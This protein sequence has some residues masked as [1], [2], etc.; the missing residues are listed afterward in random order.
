MKTPIVDFVKAYADTDT[1]R[2]HMPGHKGKEVIGS[3]KWDITEIEGA[4]VLYSANGIIKQSEENAAELFET[5]K[6]VYS[7][8]GSSLAIRAMLFLLKQYGA[9]TGKKPLIA[10]GRNAHKTFITACAL[11]DIDVTWLLPQGAEN[12]I[13]CSITPEFLDSFLNES[14][15]K[16]LAVY[17]TSPDY[18]GN[19]SDIGGLAEICRKH[20][21]LLIVDNAHGA[22]LKFLP[23]SLHPITLGADMCCDSAHKTLPV[24]TGGAYLHI[25]KKACP[26]FAENADFAMSMFAST[27]PSY[28]ILQ[29][30]D[31]AN[32][33]L[34][35]GYFN[36]LDSFIKRVESLKRAVEEKGYRLYGNEP[37]KLTIAPKTYGYTGC[38]L[39]QKLCEKG[40]V[41]EFSDMDF[42]VFMLTPQIG[43]TGLERLKQALCSIEKREEIKSFPPIPTKKVKR[44]SPAKAVF[45]KSK[46][47]EVDFC[48][49]LVCSAVSVTCPPAIPIVVCG[50]EIDRNAIESFKY[51]GIQSCVVVDENID[52]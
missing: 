27:S 28:L 5:G 2:L 22:Y 21:V 19:L 49:G 13:S 29:S 46:R 14:T 9:I 34:A 3:E 36:E 42:V 15:E 24:L 11:L 33:N 10:A 4:D 16:P 43:E 23:E 1:L 8:E 30:L 41:C 31:M 17:V 32:S 40:I 50:E 35:D 44:M 18:L 38:E 45:S 52:K 48:L 26:F 39:A 6:T 51:Y 20:E 25:S 7:T 47:L 12:L 37:L